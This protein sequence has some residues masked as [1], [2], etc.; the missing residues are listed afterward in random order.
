MAL[1]WLPLVFVLLAGLC[2]A[3]GVG[4]GIV[5]VP[6]LVLSGHH[7]SDAAALSL[8]AIVVGSGSAALVY[9]ARREVDFL[10]AALLE[11]PTM[12]MAFLGGTLSAHAPETFLRLLLASFLTLGAYAMWRG[13]TWLGGSES[14]NRRWTWTRRR[15]KDTYHIWLPVVLPVTAGVGFLSGL[16]GVTGGFLKVPVMVVLCGVPMRTAVATSIF[17]VTFTGLVGFVGHLADHPVAWST[18][19]P[20]A[21]AV[22]VGGQLGSRLGRRV[23]AET[24]RKLLAAVLLLAGLR[25]GLSPWL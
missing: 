19:L 14:A 21:A 4:G 3:I 2:S 24:L 16:L 25:I 11:P 20:L 17:M 1:L 8:A 22:A 12:L 10:L 7:L 5:Y 6:T 13:R 9:L 18:L 23:P 15:G